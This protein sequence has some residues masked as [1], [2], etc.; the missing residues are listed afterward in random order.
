M[1]THAD[2]AQPWVQ[3]PMLNPC[4]PQI[5]FCYGSTGRSLTCTSDSIPHI[6]KKKLAEVTYTYRCLARGDIPPD[7]R[8]QRDVTILYYLVCFHFYIRQDAKLSGI[9][10]EYHPNNRQCVLHRTGTRPWDEI[11][12]NYKYPLLLPVLSQET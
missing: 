10:R 12:R 4:T 1:L 6:C 8:R 11:L 2:M 3:P 7:L 5:I 9:H